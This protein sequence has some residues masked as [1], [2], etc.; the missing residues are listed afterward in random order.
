MHIIYQEVKLV[1]FKCYVPTHEI[2]LFSC[3]LWLLTSPI[4][5]RRL[6][7]LEALAFHCIV[8]D[9]DA[10]DFSGFEFAIVSMLE[11]PVNS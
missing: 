11:N 8:A 5:K 6:E 10:F 2:L 1:H 4:L 9:P 7:L 3:Y